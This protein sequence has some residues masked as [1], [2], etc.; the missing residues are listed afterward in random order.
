MGNKC[1]HCQVSLERPVTFAELF[2]WHREKQELLCE[3]CRACF[4]PINPEQV[5]PICFRPQA[6]SEICD[7][8]QKWQ[9][10]YPG[11]KGKHRSL[12][13][14]NEFAK[15]WMIQFKMRGDI[16]YGMVF[17]DLIKAVIQKYY[18]DHLVVPIPS[19][20]KSLAKRGFNQIDVIL[21]VCGLEYSTILTNHSTGVNQAKKSREERLLNEQPFQLEEEV[22]INGVKILLIDDVYTTGRTLYH[23]KEI[24][25]QAGANRIDSLSLFR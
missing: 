4:E 19:S 23:A 15:E 24:L 21:S 2:L 3:N 7:E 22:D 16:R 25:H 12:F 6:G 1:I 8:C 17:G 18:P 5:C 11:M 14:Y 9:Q 13:Q 20:S 10:K